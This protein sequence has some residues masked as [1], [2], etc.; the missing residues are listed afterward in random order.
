MTTG[1]FDRLTRLRLTL[2]ALLAE[3]F[4]RRP[5]LDEFIDLAKQSPAF[6]DLSN[7]ALVLMDALDSGMN[8]REFD[9]MAQTIRVGLGALEGGPAFSRRD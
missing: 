5:L 7:A 1:S 8:G 6:D 3:R 2:N 4:V 9:Q